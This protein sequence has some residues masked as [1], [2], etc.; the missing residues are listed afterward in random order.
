MPLTIIQEV[1]FVVNVD[2]G[3]FVVSFGVIP[4]GSFLSKPLLTY[5]R[6][7][8]CNQLLLKKISPCLPVLRPIS[9][10]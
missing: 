3:E 2:Y 1:N 5:L 8:H 9:D 7:W 10:L 6:M 4:Y